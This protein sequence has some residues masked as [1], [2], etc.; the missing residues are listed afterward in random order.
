MKL[1][2][3]KT[4]YKKHLLVLWISSRAVL[5]IMLIVSGAKMYGGVKLDFEFILTGF[6]IPKILIHTLWFILPW[7]KLYLGGFLF[8]G[9][10]TRTSALLCALFHTIALSSLLYVRLS[11]IKIYSHPCSVI[12]Y[13]DCPSALTLNT[14]IILL[15]LGIYFFNS[16][17]FTF[18]AWVKEQGN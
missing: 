13:G 3:L 14:L 4:R 5:G 17:R 9:I 2:K 1:S 7:I 10:F 8:L 18:D 6:K 11:Q 12:S 16:S 15:S